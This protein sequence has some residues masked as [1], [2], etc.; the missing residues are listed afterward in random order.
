MIAKKDQTVENIRAAL[1]ASEHQDIR[2]ED[3]SLKVLRAD[4]SIAEA[5]VAKGRMRVDPIAYLKSNHFELSRELC[6]TAAKRSTSALYSVPREMVD[7]AMLKSVVSSRP[8]KLVFV[9][10]VGQKLFGIYPET[11]LSAELMDM[12]NEAVIPQGLIKERGKELPKTTEDLDALIF[13]Y[14]VLPQLVNNI[15]TQYMFA[16]IGALKEQAARA[17][18]TAS[19]EKETMKA[20]RGDVDKL[21][22]ENGIDDDDAY[23]IS[24]AIYDCAE[25]HFCC[26]SKPAPAPEVCVSVSLVR[27]LACED[28]LWVDALKVLFDAEELK[29]LSAE[30]GLDKAVYT[31]MKRQIQ[32]GLASAKGWKQICFASR[33][34][35][36]GD[37]ANDD[38]EQLM[39]GDGYD[40]TEAVTIK[41]NQDEHLAPEAVPVKV[42]IRF[43]WDEERMV[44]GVLDMLDGTLECEAIQAMEYEIRDIE[45]AKVIFEDG[46][47]PLDPEEEFLRLAIN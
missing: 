31:L 34:Y 45:S 9:L 29:K 21:L 39:A 19:S 28:K 46:A 43:K 44:D 33:D 35:N 13:E 20:F 22:I 24:D 17:G 36:W 12:V 41:V 23:A 10:G 16:A 40:S 2:L 38:F 5:Y 1:N 3:I 14:G 6:L 25:R 47:V 7:H 8:D 26:G 27:E 30:I 37:C 32:K 42:C 4:P 15:P 18:K 11:G